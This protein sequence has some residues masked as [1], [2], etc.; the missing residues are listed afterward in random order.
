MQNDCDVLILGGGLAG[1]TL[2][3][4]VLLSHPGKR[5]IM[6]DRRAELPPKE[7]KVG[8]A[9]VQASGY[10]YGKVLQLE[11]YLLQEH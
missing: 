10:Y 9:T 5:I 8:E 2:A 3:R 7:Q 1:Q 6:A 11:E 4:Q